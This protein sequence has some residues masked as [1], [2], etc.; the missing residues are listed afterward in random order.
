MDG[1]YTTLLLPIAEGVLDGSKY[2][3]QADGYAGG[4]FAL[5]GTTLTYTGTAAQPTN[6]YLTK[7][8]YME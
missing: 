3:V 8:R 6:Y 7:I 4:T 5:S 2:M 1:Y